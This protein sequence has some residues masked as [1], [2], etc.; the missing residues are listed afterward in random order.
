MDTRDRYRAYA[1]RID[2]VS[3]TYAA[4]ARSV[5]GPLVDLLDAVPEPKRQPELLFAVARRLGA[6]PAD[7]AAL[8]ALG[9]EARPA[10][11]AALTS[12]TVQANDPRRLAPVVPVLAALSAASARPLGL[13]DVGAAAG[14]CSIP[15]RVTLDHRLVDRARPA[16]PVPSGQIPSGHI[17]SGSVPSGSVPSGPGSTQ[18]GRRSAT[19]G[20]LVRVHTAVEGPAVHLV[21]EV[22]GTP[23]A[24]ATTPIRIGARVA[25]DPNPIDPAAP[26][27]FARLAEAVPPEATDR[28]ALMRDAL[29]ATLVEP[30]VRVRGSV[31]DDLDRALDALPDDCEPVV[32]T[33]GTLVYVPGA[34]RQRFVDR[35]RERGVRWVA[36][37]RTGVLTG[38]AATLPEDVDPADPDAFATLSLDGRA[39]AVS[40]AFGTRVRW[41]APPEVLAETVG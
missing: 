25:L 3:P 23:P 39:L 33:T 7:P 10:L 35:L 8:R 12:A 37:E 1:D 34:G 13:L 11:V 30:P 15:D 18:R 5:E 40:D 4:W 38:V 16:G 32:M 26:D 21:A 9:R 2:G 20:D 22:V 29:R 27:A 6:D 14:L 28:T 19:A 31:P 41:S 17:L 36:L 24:P